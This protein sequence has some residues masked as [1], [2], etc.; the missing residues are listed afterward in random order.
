MYKESHLLS[1][2]V[3]PALF[4]S[5]L[6]SY[7]ETCPGHL[8]M[9]SFSLPRWLSLLP[10]HSSV[11]ILYY[12]RGQKEQPSSSPVPCQ[13]SSR[14]L[15]VLCLL[16]PPLAFRPWAAELGDGEQ[17]TRS[18]PLPPAQVNV[19]SCCEFPFLY[20]HWGALPCPQVCLPAFILNNN[21]AG[22]Q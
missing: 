9:E 15:S 7:D 10:R 4:L 19:T 6:Y 3:R 8:G 22:R 5:S 17:L 21:K 14:R 11:P 13:L 18:Q 2:V 16:S 1:D 12:S 20:S